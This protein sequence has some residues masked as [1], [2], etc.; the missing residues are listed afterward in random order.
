[1]PTTLTWKPGNKDFP[2]PRWSPKFNFY[3]FEGR[4]AQT[5]TK[6]FKQKQKS[7]DFQEPPAFSEERG[8]SRSRFSSSTLWASKPNR[9]QGSGFGAF[10]AGFLSYCCSPFLSQAGFLGIDLGEGTALRDSPRFARVRSNPILQ[11]PGAV[12]IFLQR[13]IPTGASSGW[14]TGSGITFSCGKSYSC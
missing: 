14:N 3:L 13:I 9:A 6:R 4:G 2:R 5:E 10:L 12:L 7:G 8:W 1:M 11:R